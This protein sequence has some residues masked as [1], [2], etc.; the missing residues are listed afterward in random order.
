MNALL[1][2][3]FIFA[4]FIRTTVCLNYYFYNIFE[5]YKMQQMSAFPKRLQSKKK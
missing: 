1:I 3:I 5:E 2:R 4:M